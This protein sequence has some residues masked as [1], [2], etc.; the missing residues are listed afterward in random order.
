VIVESTSCY[1]LFWARNNLAPSADFED[2]D[3][4]LYSSGLNQYLHYDFA[5]N[6]TTAW[7]LFTAPLLAS[8]GWRVGNVEGGAAATEAQLQAVLQSLSVIRVRGEYRT[9]ADSGDLDTITVEGAVAV[10]PEP[11]TIVLLGA[12]AALLGMRRLRR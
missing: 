12:G 7:G 3:V 10:I 4:I 11:G 9:R 1:N 2:T 5:S 6:P 8:A